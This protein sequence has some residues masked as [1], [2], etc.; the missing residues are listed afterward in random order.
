MFMHLQMEFTAVDPKG[1]TCPPV[2]VEQVTRTMEPITIITVSLCVCVCEDEEGLALGKDNVTLCYFKV[3]TDL[4]SISQPFQVRS[5]FVCF[6]LS[7]SENED[8]F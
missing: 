7:N 2:C 8:E 3:K 6:W 1:V 4:S 5:V